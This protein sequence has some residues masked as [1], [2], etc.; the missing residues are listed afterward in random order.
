[1]SHIV[2]ISEAA[3]IGIHV[4]VL[5]A[6]SKNNNM[7]VK[8]LSE[9]GASK[10][11]IAKVMQRLV[12]DNFVKSTRGPAGGFVLNM[13]PEDISLLNIY[14]SIEGELSL[15]KC[16]FDQQICPFEECLMGGIVHKVTEELREYFKNKTVKELM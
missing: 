13:A 16:P 2:N 6:R 10:N 15:T 3:T 9:L 4:V 1:M 7:N 14:E 5:I 8:R 12:K 11:H